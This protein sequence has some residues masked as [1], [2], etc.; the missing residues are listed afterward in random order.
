MPSVPAQT[1]K[2]YKKYEWQLQELARQQVF[3]RDPDEGAIFE[4]TVRSIGIESTE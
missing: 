3:R 4:V 1:Q 2:T